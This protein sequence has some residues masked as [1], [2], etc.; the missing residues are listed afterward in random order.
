[1]VAIM[2]FPFRFLF[3]FV[4]AGAISGPASAQFV[5]SCSQA[6]GAS[7]ALAQQEINLGDGVLSSASDCSGL[8]RPICEEAERHYQIAAQQLRD[9]LFDAKGEACVY[10]S[11]DAIGQNARVLFDRGEGMAQSGYANNLGDVYRD[12]LN[13]SNA[14]YCDGPTVALPSLSPQTLPVDPSQPQVLDPNQPPVQPQPSSQPSSQSQPQPQAGAAACNPKLQEY[15]S[16]LDNRDRVV[17]KVYSQAGCA[18]ICEAND[19]CRSF[20]YER[21]DFTRGFEYWCIIHPYTQNER[22]LIP[23]PDYVEESYYYVCEGR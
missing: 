20:D 14:P 23:K 18:N 17:S 19:W 8:D 22:R 12:F 10:C 2:R 21:M 4:V 15:N 1:M 13:W 6:G 7:V 9:V 11:L 3:A 16:V 5:E